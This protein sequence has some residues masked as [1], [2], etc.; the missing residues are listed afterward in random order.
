MMLALPFTT[1][2]F[3]EVF[4]RYNT[5]LW[6]IQLL[7]LGLALACL[8]VIALPG[9]RARAVAW[10]LALLWAWMGIAYHFAFFTAINP[11]AWAFG[12]LS[13]VG[14]ALFGWHAHRGTLV[15]RWQPGLRGVFGVALIAYALAGYPALGWL[16][17][18]RYPAVPTFGLPCPTTIFTLGMLLFAERPV[19]RAVFVVPLLW[20]CVG[21]V[22]AFSLG[23]PQDLGL[24]AAALV[25]LAALR[26]AGTNAASASRHAALRRHREA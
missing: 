16:L 3:Y 22:A 14:A 12:A 7:L 8:V 9:Q 26:S 25:A 2:E 10:T 4:A 1:A 11:A 21:T 5:A 23:V 24:L 17:G 6:P 15:F 18:A 20:A 19:P 13:L